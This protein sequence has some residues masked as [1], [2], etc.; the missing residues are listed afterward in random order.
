MRQLEKAICDLLCHLQ[1]M[2]SGFSLPYTNDLPITLIVSVRNQ[3]VAS[4]LVLAR[5]WVGLMH[6]AGGG[7]TEA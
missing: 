1:L 7:R 4:K 5:E 3:V 2:M 6:G